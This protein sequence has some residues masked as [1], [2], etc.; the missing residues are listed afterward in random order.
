MSEYI[1]MTEVT[2][3]LGVSEQT[4]RNWI[5]KSKLP[6]P[7]VVSAKGWRLWEKDDIERLAQERA[8]QKKEVR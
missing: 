6:P 4:I 1:G 8:N 5:T 2:H 3:L 7:A